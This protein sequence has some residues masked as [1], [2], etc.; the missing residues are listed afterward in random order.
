MTS[1]EFH[2]CPVGQ[3]SE[4]FQRID[5][6]AR[7]TEEGDRLFFERVDGFP[8][9]EQLQVGG[10]VWLAP[11]TEQMSAKPRYTMTMSLV[12]SASWQG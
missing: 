5:P 12:G 7:V 6:R 4:P 3:P 10:W 9:L 1:L 11:E 2:A 8:F